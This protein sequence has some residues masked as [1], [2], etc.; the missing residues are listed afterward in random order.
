MASFFCA[1]FDAKIVDDKSESSSFGLVA[2][3]AGGDWGWC[4][5]VRFEVFDK[6]VEGQFSD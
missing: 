4:A 1:G 5:S 3:E 6:T 2:P